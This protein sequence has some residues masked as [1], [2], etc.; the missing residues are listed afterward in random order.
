MKKMYFLLTALLISFN[1]N[2]LDLTTMAVKVSSDVNKTTQALEN[3]KAEHKAKKEEYKAKSKAK[4]E[5]IKNKIND[6]KNE[7]KASKKEVEDSVNN[8]KD[9]LVL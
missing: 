6:K 3:K 5:E 2:A 4:K 1:A 7:A 9:V 8:L